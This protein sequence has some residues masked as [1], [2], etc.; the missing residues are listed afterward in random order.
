MSELNQAPRSNPDT[1]P[2]NELGSRL[3]LHVLTDRKWSRGRD[4]L[5]VATAALAGGATVIQLRDKR[6]STRTLV[7][8]GMA[9]RALTRERGALLI[10]N[11]RVDVAL[12]VDADGVHVGQEDLP[13]ALAR[14]MLGPDRILGVSIATLQETEEAVAAGADYLGVGPV[15]ATATKADAGPATGTHLLTECAR[16]FALPLIAIG[17]ITVANAAQVILAGASGIAVITAVVHAE[18]VTDA[19]QQLRRVVETARSHLRS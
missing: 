4:M 5:T 2:L 17:G 19:A 18:D 11:D 12:A 9:L 10:V 6:A 3:L 15:F 13:A 16:R 14:R 1:R 8:E 7:E